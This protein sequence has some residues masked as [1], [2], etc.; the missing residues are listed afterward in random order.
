MGVAF[1]G[2]FMSLWEKEA[3]E[4]ENNEVTRN[5]AFLLTNTQETEP[6]EIR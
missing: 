4:K 5:S 2:K 1:E 3:R 6:L